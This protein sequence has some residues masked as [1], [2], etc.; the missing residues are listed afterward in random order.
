MTHLCVVAAAQFKQVALGAAVAKDTVELDEGV[1]T[2]SHTKRGVCLVE[3][4]VYHVCSHVGWGSHFK[5]VI[6]IT[7]TC[8]RYLQ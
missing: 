2:Y 1:S 4:Q 3:G 5:Y 8:T 6:C 7:H